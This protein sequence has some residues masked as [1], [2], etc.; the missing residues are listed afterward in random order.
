[1]NLSQS[2]DVVAFRL[3]RMRKAPRNWCYWVAAFTAVNGL[4]V[5]TQ[6]DVLFLAGFVFPY[7][8]EGAWLHFASAVALAAV[9][10]FGQ[11]NRI[12]YAMALVI[13]VLD[14]TFAGYVQMWSG[15]VMHVV[16]LAF[17]ALAF[18]GARLLEKQQSS[19]HRLG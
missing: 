8:I 18:K 4:L 7:I 1:M 11:A 3:Q 2:P 16:V 13:Y 14:A 9:G 12:L 17:V 5:L 10:H 19:P 15:V 6:P